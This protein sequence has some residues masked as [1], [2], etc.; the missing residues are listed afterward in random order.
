MVFAFLCMAVPCLGN[1]N[2][3][4]LLKQIAG[5]DPAAQRSA[6]KKLSELSDT[7]T[8][9]TLMQA[10]HNVDWRI[11]GIAAANL[12]RFHNPQIPVLLKKALDDSSEFVRIGAVTG[13]SQ[14]SATQ[15]MPALKYAL[16][17][18]S[19]LVRAA[20]AE[21]LGER[22]GSCAAAVLTEALKYP[23]TKV[24]NAAVRS[25]VKLIEHAGSLKKSEAVKWLIL[26]IQSSV[27]AVRVA[28]AEAL[29]ETGGSCAVAALAEALKDPVPAV[30]AASAKVLSKIGDPKSVGMMILLLNLHLFTKDFFRF[31]AL[32]LLIESGC[33]LIILVIFRVIIWYIDKKF[34]S[35]MTRR[36][37]H[38]FTVRSALLLTVPF[39]LYRIA[40]STQALSL[41]FFIL[42][43]LVSFCAIAF[44][45][46]KLTSLFYRLKPLGYVLNAWIALGLAV[47]ISVTLFATLHGGARNG[48]VYSLTPLAAT[49]LGAFLFLSSTFLA[50]VWPWK[51]ACRQAHLLLCSNCFIR[52]FGVNNRELPRPVRWSNRRLVEEKRKRHEDFVDYFK[53]ARCKRAAGYKGISKVVGLL[54]ARGFI[55][56]VKG[57][58]A[59]IG[60]WDNTD[61]ESRGADIDELEVHPMPRGADCFRAINSVILELAADLRRP[62][63]L[64]D[65]PVRIVGRP[66]LGP[67]AVSLLKQKFRGIVT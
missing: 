35:D 39:W 46:C 37:K 59:Y 64:E 2:A 17:D 60:L 45:L 19:W 16:K 13:L 15:S 43:E 67:G 21:A 30:R 24:H 49:T 18:K 47:T 5:N 57:K 7:Q 28:S 27:P 6:A 4:L 66:H 1:D 3:T 51:S 55:Q 29:G 58:T 52:R 26:T 25:L 10:I 48:L 23:D 14:L 42:I 50:C 31:L 56:E 40:L 22:G 36:I 8:M 38:L 53:C 32:N 34:H 12:G 9:T 20:S 62:R 11:R 65:I 54:S 44:G 41:D 61:M 33:I 63:G